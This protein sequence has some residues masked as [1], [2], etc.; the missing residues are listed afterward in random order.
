[1]RRHEREPVTPAVPV[2][3]AAERRFFPILAA[4]GLAVIGLLGFHVLSGACRHLGISP[5]W[6]AIILAAA[7][8]DLARTG[9]LPFT[10][11][12][13]GFGFAILAAALVPSLPGELAA[14]SVVGF[15]ST[16]FMA[17]GNTTLQ[18]TADPQ[19]RG[20]VM[21]LWSVTFTGR[22][23]IGEPVV[24]VIADDLGP[25]YGLG[26]GAVACLAATVIGALAV[27]SMPPADRYARR[28]RELDWPAH[29]QAHETR[30]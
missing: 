18:L 11:A 15:F 12:A 24:G 29:Q 5:G 17:T 2:V 30:E 28:P 27:S 4:A 14:L 13:A 6:M 26:L 1:V 22:T 7:L 23:P 3:H 8:A 19:F 16:A 20:R 21:A 9:I 25:R 10:V